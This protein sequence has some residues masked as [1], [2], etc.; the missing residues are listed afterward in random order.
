MA[1]GLDAPPRQALA[2]TAVKDLLAEVVVETRMVMTLSRVAT[3][4][5]PET[6]PPPPRAIP[7]PTHRGHRPPAPVILSPGPV[8]Q[9]VITRRPSGHPR[10]VHQ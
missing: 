5:H 2:V 6:L 3:T 7:S 1:V 10:L 8:R 4:G 9:R